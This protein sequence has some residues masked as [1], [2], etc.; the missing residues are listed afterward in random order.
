MS[1]PGAQAY[2]KSIVAMYAAWSVDFIKADDM[3]RPYH[4]AEIEGLHKAILKSGRRTVLS[5]SPRPAPLE[6]VQSLRA[7]AQMWRIEDDLWDNWQ[8]L[9]KM[10]ARIESWPTLVQPGHWPDA[11]MLRLGHVG[12]RAECGNDRL[13][14]LTHD[15]QRT[16]ITM[17]TIT[18]SPLM[19]SGDL[20]TL[21]PFTRSLL[22]N[23]AV[24]EVN[25]HSTGNRLA[26][27]TGN[28]RVWT[29]NSIPGRGAQVTYIAIFNLG[30]EPASQQ[31]PWS[32][33]RLKAP[34]EGMRDLWSRD[35]V[36]AGLSLAIKLP[37]HACELYRL[38]I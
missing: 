35:T 20:A 4:Q 19:F 1:K 13:S 32:S 15:E 2:Y 23:S 31:I 26:Y 7:N 3:A 22:S 34:T 24:L 17:W 21:D 33:L 8:L 5:L 12:I 30:D 25:Q 27:N 37:P 6:K 29:A 38:P 11:D 10:A 9:N 28:L 16:M 18:R 14:S 36:K